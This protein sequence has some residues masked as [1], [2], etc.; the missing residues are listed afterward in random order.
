MT[1]LLVCNTLEGNLGNGTGWKRDSISVDGQ[2]R[3]PGAI[4]AGAFYHPSMTIAP[5][6]NSLG[7]FAC[8]ENIREVR[9]WRIDRNRNRTVPSTFCVAGSSD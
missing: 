2:G 1:F 5:G 3:G 8:G 9:P 4:A 6:L 7:A